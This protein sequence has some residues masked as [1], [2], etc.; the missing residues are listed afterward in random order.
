MSF[1][2][3]FT[4]LIT[5][6]VKTFELKLNADLVGQNYAL[7]KIDKYFLVK[8]VIPLCI[9]YFMI[10]NTIFTLSFFM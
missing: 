7:I 3:I 4:F 5:M 1:T 9:V 2:L 8:F 6:I 10:I